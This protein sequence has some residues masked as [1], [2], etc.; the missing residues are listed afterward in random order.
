MITKPYTKILK[1]D[2][3]AYQQVSQAL[4]LP[5]EQCLFIDDQLKNIEGA[6]ALNMPYVHFDVTDPCASY[7][8]VRAA[9]V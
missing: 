3:R 2:P 9:Y 5:L 6:Q 1:P 8:K 7:Q 4:D